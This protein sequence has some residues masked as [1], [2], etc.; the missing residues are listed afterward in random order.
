MA[1]NDV[2][3][4]ELK[5]KL[6]NKKAYDENY[7]RIFGKKEELRQCDITENRKCN[8]PTWTLGCCGAGSKS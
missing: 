8:C 3:G 4:D 5:S 1:T 7:D 6:G 2:T